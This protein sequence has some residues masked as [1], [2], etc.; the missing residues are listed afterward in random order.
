MS[1]HLL[2]EAKKLL[3]DMLD[4]G[5]AQT[6]AE[7]L[8]SDLNKELNVGEKYKTDNYLILRFNDFGSKICTVLSEGGSTAAIEQAKK[9]IEEG[10]YDSAVVVRV[11][12]NSKDRTRERWEAA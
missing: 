9:E 5:I 7:A 11:L 3:E 4:K 2:E 10:L 12:Y 1:R 8:L 6:R